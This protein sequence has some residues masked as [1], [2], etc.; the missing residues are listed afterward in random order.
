MVNQITIDPVEIIND[1]S[2]YLTIEIER[3]EIIIKDLETKTNPQYATKEVIEFYRG[4]LIEL[5]HLKR[6]WE[7]RKMGEPLN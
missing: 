3:K 2:E 1:F 5:K 4:A 6:S 7:L